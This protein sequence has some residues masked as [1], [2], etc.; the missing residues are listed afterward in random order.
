MKLKIKNK[1]LYQGWIDE[2]RKDHEQTKNALIRIDKGNFSY[3]ATGVLCLS[4]EKHKIVQRF[5]IK[6]RWAEN[7]VVRQEKFSYFRFWNDQQASYSSV[8][9]TLLAD[10]L[11]HNDYINNLLQD[12]RYHCIEALNDSN[13]NLTFSQFADLLQYFMDNSPDLMEKEVTLER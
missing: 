12:D 9:P 4:L 7:G 13:D 3:C 2:L 5:T 6:A 10:Q 1:E 11:Q 8:I